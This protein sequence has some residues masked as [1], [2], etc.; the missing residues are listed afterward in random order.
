MRK[1]LLVGCAA[2]MSISANAQLVAQNGAFGINT[3]IEDTRTGLSWLRLDLTEGL[4][5][6]EVTSQLG[7]GGMFS[8]YQLASYQDVQGLLSNIVSPPSPEYINFYQF[9]STD[10]LVVY[11]AIQFTTL[12]GGE[13]EPSAA[14]QIGS[15][16]EGYYG[17]PCTIQQ[18]CPLFSASVGWD[19]GPNGSRA[20]G[21][22]DFARNR[23]IGLPSVG[24]YLFAAP[25]P[26]PATWAMLVAGLGALGFVASRRK[27]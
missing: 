19:L 10:P 3:L 26:E 6:A 25:V 2:L 18:T 17:S 9:G 14:G 20:G 23:N 5:F 21:T 24:T 16:V 1:L 11:N 12:F 8:G 13:V 22:D 4:S 27:A 15:R 7:A